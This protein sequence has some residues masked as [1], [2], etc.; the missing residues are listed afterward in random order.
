MA[1]KI[2]KQKREVEELVV[3]DV[4]CNICEKSLKDKCDMNYEGLEARICG[5]YASIL[6][7]TVSYDFA[8]CEECLRD[9]IFPMFK[10]EPD[11]NDPWEAYAELAE[12][13]ETE[14]E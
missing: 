14:E 9:K 3:T 12:A 4:V 1:K 13:E 7:D 11:I 5:G 2:E 6:G 8:I 10:I